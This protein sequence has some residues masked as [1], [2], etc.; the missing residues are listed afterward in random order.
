MTARDRF[1][2]L[3]SQAE[4]DASERRQ[5]IADGVTLFAIGFAATAGALFALHWIWRMIG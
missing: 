1:P 3:L 2:P 5:R 4:I